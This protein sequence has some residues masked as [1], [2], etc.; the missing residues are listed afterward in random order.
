MIKSRQERER[1]KRELERER[2]SR[3]NRYSM[4]DRMKKYLD[5]NDAAQV[6]Q[7]ISEFN[8]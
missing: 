6:R 7:F 8:I 4:Y 1:E 2:M 5:Y 3:R